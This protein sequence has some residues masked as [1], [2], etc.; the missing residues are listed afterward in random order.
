[1]DNN[2]WQL[3][4]V[5]QWFDAVQDLNPAYL[6]TE[7]YILARSI[8][9]DLGLRVPHSIE[10][11]IPPSSRIIPELQ[12]TGPTKLIHSILNMQLPD[13]VPCTH[14]GCLNHMTHPC[15]GCGRIAGRTR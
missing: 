9:E 5:R 8:Y 10:G 4:L 7:D 6:T 11:R 14:S 12:Y 15:E 1:M 13:G 3:E 2:N